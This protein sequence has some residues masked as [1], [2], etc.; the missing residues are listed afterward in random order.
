M[1]QDYR[2]RNVEQGG[3]GRIA[4]G[5]DA[6]FQKGGAA[7]NVGETV[8][9]QAAC[10]G[11]GHREREFPLGHPPG[12]VSLKRLLASGEDVF[13]KPRLDHRP[14]LAELFPG[15]ICG[16]FSRGQNDVVFRKIRVETDPHAKAG[17]IRIGHRIVHR[18]LGEPEELESKGLYMEGGLRKRLPEKRNHPPNEHPLRLGGDARND[19][20]NP[21]LPPQGKTC[22][23]PRRVGDDLRPLRKEGLLGVVLRPAEPPSFKKGL[24]M[25]EDGGIAVQTQAKGLGQSRRRNVIGR[26]AKPPGHDHRVDARQQ[27]GK[28]ITD[29]VIV[30]AHG[31]HPGNRPPLLLHRTGDQRGIGILGP[32][33]RQ[34]VS[35]RQY[36]CF[37]VSPLISPAT[38]SEPEAPDYRKRPQPDR[39]QPPRNRQEAAPERAAL[40]RVLRYQTA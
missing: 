17:E 6:A 23:R 14:G 29:G 30:I 36:A 21:P 1:L 9:D 25:R 26:G 12:N 19:G 38:K 34:L 11:F 39:P 28:R 5:H 31:D 32:T 37:H 2:L 7:G 10:A 22:C 3:L 4:V 24:D 8:R 13:R 40:E 18:R 15:H 33:A 16:G 35:N 27:M 20:D